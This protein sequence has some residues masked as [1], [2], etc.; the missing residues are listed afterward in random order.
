VGYPN[1]ALSGAEIIILLLGPGYA[2]IRTLSLVGP[3]G[4]S[5]GARN[6]S[7]RP[8]YPWMFHL[9]SS[10]D[11]RTKYSKHSFLKALTRM[12]EGKASVRG[13]LI[14]GLACDVI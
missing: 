7:A 8:E 14:S 6:T 13:S 11:L 4:S 10:L 2:L 5:L 3:L 1:A 9:T 12:V